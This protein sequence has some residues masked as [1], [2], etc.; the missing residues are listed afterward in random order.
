MEIVTE[1][2]MRNGKS[3][4]SAK[5]GTKSFSGLRNIHDWKS[6]KSRFQGKKLLGGIPE[7]FG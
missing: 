6:I 3:E 1:G 2:Q 7:K 4:S 5:W